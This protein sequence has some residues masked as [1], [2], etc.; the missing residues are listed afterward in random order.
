MPLL[1]Y[2]VMPTPGYDKATVKFMNKEHMLSYYKGQYQNAHLD[3][4]DNKVIQMSL[5]GVH[6]VEL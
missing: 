4:L 5:R 2:V 6:N 3:H 1:F